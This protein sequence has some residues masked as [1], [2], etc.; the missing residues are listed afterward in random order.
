VNHLAK[1]DRRRGAA[2]LLPIASVLVVILALVAA[3]SPA[4]GP[5]GSPSTPQ[6]GASESVPVPSD[7]ATPDLSSP[8]PA[9]SPSP[10][11]S[12]SA[13][14]SGGASPTPAPT[15]APTRRPSP[16]PTAAGGDTVILRAYL[17]MTSDGEPH[18]V[19]V[20]R[21]V[22]A[23]VAVARAATRQ[24]LAGPTA[25][26]AAAGIGTAI[27][28]GTTLLGVAIEDGVATVDLSREFESGG[29][30]E[31]MF[32]RLAQV[33]YTLTQF[34]T[35]DEVLFRLDGEPVTVFG[36]EGIVLDGPV[37]RADYRDQLPAIFIDRPAWG[38]SLG[39]PGRVGGVANVFE[40]TF[41]IELSDAAGR[42]L[43]DRQVMA[44]CGTGCWGTWSLSLDYTVGQ[45]QWGRLRVYN[46]SAKDGSVEDAVDYR[47]WLTPASG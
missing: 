8:S 29:G 17:V 16:S 27:P 31:S 42:T 34:R 45:G 46:L 38:A 30:S 10:S 1:P 12:A 35:V 6:P 14:P 19:P 15:P 28:D 40:A 36:G 5:L 4:V 41:R 21:E 43:V 44:S 33:V 23:T 32:L 22:P 13:T 24:L 9:V 47:V 2:S 25:D 26:E 37:G 3:C 11:G 18:L 39:N 20:L 7:D